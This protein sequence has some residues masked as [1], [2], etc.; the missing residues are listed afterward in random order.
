MRKK[1]NTEGKVSFL[2]LSRDVIYYFISF[3]K[4][5]I[6]NYLDCKTIF[7]NTCPLKCKVFLTRIQKKA[8]KFTI[9]S[10]H[11]G[12]IVPSALFLTDIE[13]KFQYKYHYS[14]S[15]CQ[16]FSKQIFENSLY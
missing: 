1:L 8:S 11:Q 5:I 10:T 7:R 2:I 14:L 4:Q 9:G 13:D 12:F 3:T 15:D 6:R 16:T